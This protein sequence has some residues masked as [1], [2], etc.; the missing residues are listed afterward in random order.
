MTDSSIGHAGSCSAE[1]GEQ[2]YI[3]SADTPLESII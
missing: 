3:T 2:I 1:A